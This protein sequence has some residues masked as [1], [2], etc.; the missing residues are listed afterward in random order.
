[1]QEI[2]EKNQAYTV[3]TGRKRKFF[4]LAM[5]CQMNMHDSEKLEGML[6][7]MGYEKTEVETEADF[8]I[9]N[10]C[11]VRENAEVKVYGKLGWLKHYKK[12]KSDLLVA[13]CGCMTQQD[14]VLS[15]LRQK[16]RHVDIVFGT[17]NLYKLP[18]L[19]TTRLENGSAVYDI[20][21]EH[22][23]ILEDL[24][25][26]RK[27]WFKASINIMYGCDNF[28]TYCV[29]P[30]V[31]GRERS[32]TSDDIIAEAKKLVADG[33]KEITLL[34][35]NVNS[36]G[37]GLDEEITFAHLLR[38]LNTVE[39]L[40]R[41]RFATSH[42]KDVSDDLILAMKECDK[43]CALLHLP[44]QAGSSRI[45]QKMNRHYTKESYLAL[46]E[47]V[48]KEIPEMSFSTD[49]MVGFPEEEEADFLDT[50]EVITKVGFAMAYTFIYSKRTGTPAAL[51]EQVPEDVVNERFQ[52]MMGIVNPTIFER[53]KEQ[54]GKT[55]DVLVEEVTRRNPTVLTG[56]ADN[57]MLVH[58]E[59]SDDCI[60]EMVSVKIVDHTTF[61]LK[62]VLTDEE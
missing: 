52:R 30:Y 34:G 47:K 32:R 61:Y 62:A 55:L 26:V 54:V 8:V 3:E 56:R 58:F 14:T 40:M 12:T 24:P 45:L 2:S 17:F 36:Y 33:V 6:G 28:C 49:I 5:G 19:I 44:F 43:V 59:G 57:N 38:K 25:A 23:E 20:W 15:T 11:C 41:I 35:Q 48:K 18:E 50:L 51:R 13:L 31:R 9:Y 37:K 39:G 10:T 1:M 53:H 42:P 7:E 46:I 16:H 27:Q 29:V 60:G 22:K 4:S 21:Q